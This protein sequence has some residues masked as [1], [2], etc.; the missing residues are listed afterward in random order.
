M[1]R[2]IE[3]R[4]AQLSP[5]ALAL[6][7]VAAVAAPDFALELAAQVLGQP[8]MQFADAL[9]EL[10]AA[11]VMRDLQFAH[12]LVHDAV[13]ASVPPAVARHT[14]AAVAAWLEVH[15]G[16][17]ARVAGHWQH[18]GQPARAIPWLA[19]AA[20]AAGR[21]VRRLEQIRFLEAQSELEA[22]HGQPD[23]AFDTLLRAAELQ[24]T[25][26]EG[27][28]GEQQCDR[29]DALARS[30]AQR[31]RA[32][33][34]RV[35]RASMRG[36][37]ALDEQLGHDTLREALREGVDEALVVQCRHHLA[38]ALVA[39]C[40][41]E[42]L[43]Q[44]EAMLPWVRAHAGAGFRCEF[45]GN[46]AIAY[47]NAGRL[48]DAHAQH[49]LAVAAAREAGEHGNLA[50][51]LA[52][53]G[54]HRMIAGHP[55]DAEALLAQARL[56]RA[57][58]DAAASIDAYVA[59]SQLVCDYAQGRYARALATLDEVESGLGRF[60]PAHR[61]FALTH[62][63]VVWAQLGQ[64]ARL[65]SL[66][67]EIDGADSPLAASGNFALRRVLLQEDQAR[68]QGREPAPDALPRAL[69][70][71]AAGC[72]LDMVALV[73][74]VLLLREPGAGVRARAEAALDHLRREGQ[75]GALLGGLAR[76]ARRAAREGDGAASR[77]LAGE[78]LALT[79]AGVMPPREYPLEPVRHLV[80]AALERGEPEA[81]RP[82]LREALAWLQARLDQ[83]DVPPA[84][85]DGFVERNPCNRGL[86]ALAARLG[87]EPL[88]I[89]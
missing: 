39:A 13:R 63:A 54:A 69:A 15:G 25:V 3:R 21:A 43:Q 1:G 41:P 5:P 76:A 77:R 55:A 31:V 46:L 75:H 83:G 35:H 72:T 32:R 59:M 61:P 2:L 8:V 29:L 64:W 48:A 80:L 44:M 28:A 49:L 42:A 47:E 68:A 85:R 34:Q 33:L 57:Q 74:L 11:H 7:R 53:H 14:H 56:V 84:C 86:R 18:A 30:A 12:D 24:V 62:R 52:N 22:A 9:N 27:D 81:A 89:G 17:P 88:T 19:R 71:A 60:A 51:T 58:D 37:L 66:F 65:Q 78:A 23:A 6:A 67:D 26:D 87:L 73:Q 10:E 40:R 20:E 50:L 36:D 79:A 4:L 45:F 38:M 16:E 70:M 82:L